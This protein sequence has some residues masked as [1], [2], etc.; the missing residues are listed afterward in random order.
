M[1]I[2]LLKVLKTA[3]WS[4]ML[5]LGMGLSCFAAAKKNDPGI[6]PL[7]PLC[8]VVQPLLLIGAIRFIGRHGAFKVFKF[9]ELDPRLATGAIAFLICGLCTGFLLTQQA[10]TYALVFMMSA[11]TIAAFALPNRTRKSPCRKKFLDFLKMRLTEWL[12]IGALIVTIVTGKWLAVVASLVLTWGP[13]SPT[14]RLM[15]I[16]H[17]YILKKTGGCQCGAC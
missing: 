10:L 4:V 15:T 17:G 2:R 16:L 6:A 12:C 13:Q 5:V 3:F 8:L 11:V 14:D 7:L 9:K 1:G